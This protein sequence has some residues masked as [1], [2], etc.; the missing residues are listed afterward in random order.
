MH[1]QLIPGVPFIHTYGL[2]LVIGFYAAYFLARRTARREGIDPN[3]MID[4]LL[5]AAILGIVGS[6]L[7]Y[8]VQFWDRIHGFVDLIA[9]WRGGLVFYGGLIFATIGLL[10]YIRRKKLPMWRLADAA[11]PAIM[12]GVMFGRLGCFLNG[13]CWGDVC[14]DDFAL[15]VRFPRLI[16]TTRI[17]SPIVPADGTWY[18]TIESAG[19]KQTLP[20][21]E[22]ADRMQ[23]APARWQ[24][25]SAR[26]WRVRRLPDGALVQDTI[27]GSYAY[28]QHL[29][30]HPDR[31]TPDAPR[32]LPV[33]A[34][35]LHASLSGLLICAVLLVY[36][37]WRRRPG[38]VFAL[39]GCLYSVARFINEN[40]RHDTPP[41]LFGMSI[42]QVISVIV[43][44][45]GAVAIVVCRT[46]GRKA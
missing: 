22:L 16:Q 35:Q 9:I 12:L 46:T 28:L 11:A 20:W 10:I 34:T 19:T 38:E 32:S 7:F 17:E 41:M 13:C 1:P 8:V 3:R 37:R 26:H 27:S 45:V 43:F 15:G 30:E 4:I 36:W 40:L 23:K 44:V 24:N 18:A 29:A 2:M 6:R 21:R 5:L 25:L 42:S 14:G 31:I 33:Y 39:M